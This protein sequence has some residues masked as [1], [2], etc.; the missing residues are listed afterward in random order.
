MHEIKVLCSA[1]L[2]TQAKRAARLGDGGHGRA[3]PRAYRLALDC[4]ELHPDAETVGGCCLRARCDRGHVRALAVACCLQTQPYLAGLLDHH[5]HRPPRR[6][7][8]GRRANGPA[9]HHA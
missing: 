2:E 1:V 4:H 8:A 6:R 7:T 5:V 9:L 3:A